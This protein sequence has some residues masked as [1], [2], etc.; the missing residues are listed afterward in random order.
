MLDPT[1]STSTHTGVQQASNRLQPAGTFT[2]ASE[3]W[4]AP[5]ASRR[6]AR[7]RNHRTAWQPSPVRER[8]SLLH[9]RAMN[10]RTS[11]L[12]KRLQHHSLD[13]RDDGCTV[14]FDDPWLNRIEVTVNV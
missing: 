1:T 12:G 8:R 4:L 11:A 5:A 6:P 13:T 10:T 2:C 14:S 3:M 7:V 9:H